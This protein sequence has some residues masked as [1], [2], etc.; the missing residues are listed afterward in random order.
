[1]SQEDIAMFVERGIIVKPIGK[2]SDVMVGTG[3]WNIYMC[4]HAWPLVAIG[5]S[6]LVG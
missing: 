4:K 2:V 1:M 6:G 5:S 3:S